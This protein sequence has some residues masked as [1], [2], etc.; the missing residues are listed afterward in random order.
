MNLT[1]TNFFHQLDKV[2]V[3]ISNSTGNVSTVLVT[4]FNLE[5]TSWFMDSSTNS[6]PLNTSKKT[7][8]AE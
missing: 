3:E 8:L 6:C 7:R 2:S 1:S 4:S 5:K